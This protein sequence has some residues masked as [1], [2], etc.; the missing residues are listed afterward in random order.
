MPADIATR[1]PSN[2]EV[3]AHELEKLRPHIAQLGVDEQRFGRIVL[4]E[5][6][7]NPELGKCTPRSLY[8]A[9][10]RSAEYRL[11]PAMGES[12]LIP[13]KGQVCWQ[14]GYKGVIELAARSGIIIETGVVHEG[15]HFVQRGGTDP[16][17]EHTPDLNAK[18]PAIAYYAVARFP[19]G[20]TLHRVL[21]KDEVEKRRKAGKTK[22]EPGRPW[23]DWYDQMA[24]KTAILALMSNVPLSGELRQALAAD[25][26]V[27][28]IGVGGLEP[29]EEDRLLTASGDV[30][31]PSTGEVLDVYD[32]QD[33]LP[34]DEAP[35]VPE[36]PKTQSSSTD[37][38]QPVDSPS[39][40]ASANDAPP[41]PLT[42]ESAA[43]ASASRTLPTHPTSTTQQRQILVLQCK[44]LGHVS[45]EQRLGF[46]SMVSG[47]EVDSFKH[48]SLDE[49][50]DLIAALAAKLEDWRRNRRAR[51]ASA[52][53]NRGYEVAALLSSRR[54][55]PLDELRADQ[56]QTLIDELEAEQSPDAQ[57]SNGQAVAAPATDSASQN[58]QTRAHY[59]ALVNTVFPGPVSR[60]RWA[61][62]LLK[63]RDAESVDDLSE[64]ALAE[65]IA[66]LE[67][68]AKR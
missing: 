22:F 43:S 60:G 61:E 66:T 32:E 59:D 55:P 65:E 47:R 42:P 17:I 37:A 40:P 46:A 16:G 34:F 62:Q 18:G 53:G 2:I 54:L 58:P 5:L 56:A 3:L 24:R 7:R 38:D 21:S 12:W 8:F 29:V 51:L 30:V 25:N 26:Q 11:D 4:N 28:T 9:V 44:E 14:I 35:R 36:D 50:R 20:R 23:H 57:P 52:A 39:E 13:R 68:K 63:R 33:V 67:K 48:L 1:E 64:T 49:A 6:Q 10:L 41:A 15:E 27:Q 45:R 31:D 19:D